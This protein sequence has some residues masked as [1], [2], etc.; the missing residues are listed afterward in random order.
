VLTEVLKKTG[1]EMQIIDV[2]N[3]DAD[4]ICALHQ[5]RLAQPK[6]SVF[7]TGVKRDIN[8]L[9]KVNAKVGDEIT[10]LDI[11][12]DKNRD[13]LL[14]F[15]SNGAKVTSFDHHFAGY[16]PEILYLV[17]YINTDANMCISLLVN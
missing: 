11:S 14:E 12:L 9:H 15:L 7:V 4:G 5:L 17:V 16:M 6:E 13:G 10:V 3:G 1:K 2:F 8:L